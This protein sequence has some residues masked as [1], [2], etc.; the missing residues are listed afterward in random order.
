MAEI[1]SVG[2]DIGTSTTQVVFSRISMDNLAGYFTAPR[3][4]ITNKEIIYKSPVYFT[5]LRTN[6]LIDGEKVRDIIAKE[7][8]SAGFSPEDVDT[9][10]V[11]ITGESARKEN[12][13]V[14]LENLSNFA[15]EF[16]V[17]TAGPDLESIIAGK[18]SGA[19]SYSLENDLPV[20]NLDV[21]GGTTNIV[22]FDCGETVGKACF[23]IGGRLIR[24]SEGRITYI[25]ES[26]R[27]IA[28][29]LGID[30]MPGDVPEVSELRQIT[31]RMAELLAQATG[32]SHRFRTREL[33]E[34]IRTSGSSLLK[35]DF[36]P[37]KICFSGGVAEYI[38]KKNEGDPFRFGDI[39]PL[40]SESIAGNEAFGKE[41]LLPAKE[42]IQATVVGAGT[43]TT[44]LSGSTI[45]YSPGIFPVKSV[46]V[47]KLSR[48]ECEAVEKGNED[49]LRDKVV[50]FMEQCDTSLIILAMEGPR[51]PTYKELTILGS[52]IVKVLD[53]VLS[54]DEPII[55]V[56]E[57]DIA[58]ALG[59][60]MKQLGSGR[61]IA[62]I[63]GVKVE[64]NDYL[65]IGRPL[66]NGLV[67]PVI[68]KTLLFG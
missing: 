5:P 10:A 60:V 51:D 18:G 15:G 16:V 41:R 25:S 19:Y 11:I 23:D 22:Q 59:V 21:G 36:S 50:W 63:D 46:P 52:T 35:E 17:S 43:Y 13:Q 20:I 7:Y 9:G 29:S 62:S 68:V 44:S 45:S 37:A 38:Y 28:A 42:T 64:G 56:T 12:A 33:L 39:G 48:L 67:V 66:M 40:L 24:I 54:K 31:D 49:L 4:A 6:I 1:L 61:R 30:I 57:H 26:A 27:E 47:L 32:L 55:V 14:V 3:I 65:D 34:K 53:S 58:K 8:K 2:I